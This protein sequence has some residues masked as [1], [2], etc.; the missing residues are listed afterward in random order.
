MGEQ[1]YSYGQLNR[2]NIGKWSLS[3]VSEKI[4]PDN[5]GGI[6][7]RGITVDKIFYVIVEEQP[8]FTVESFDQRVLVDENQLL[9]NE[10][11]V[12]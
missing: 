6:A 4:R 8:Q 12:L 10:R 9:S 11:N 3:L 5:F 7:E 2:G 1:G